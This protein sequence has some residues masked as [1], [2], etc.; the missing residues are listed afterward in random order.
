[1]QDICFPPGPLCEEKVPAC[2]MLAC[3]HGGTCS[4][5]GNTAMCFCMPGYSGETCQ[6]SSLLMAICLYLELYC[7]VVSLMQRFNITVCLRIII[8]QVSSYCKCSLKSTSQ[9]FVL[10]WTHVEYAMQSSPR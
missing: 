7:S 5:V 8:C 2:N 1:M 4:V 9:H 3:Q 6:V 10:L